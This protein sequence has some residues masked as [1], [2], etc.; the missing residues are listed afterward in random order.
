M[1]ALFKWFT[2]GGFNADGSREPWRSPYATRAPIEVIV[3][4]C[5]GVAW[6]VSFLVGTVSTRP[7]PELHGRGAVILLAII[8]ADRGRGR[9]PA[10][11]PCLAGVAARRRA[12]GK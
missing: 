5:F 6:L 4:R 8:S 7:Y 2:H 11:E 9:H 3:V 10:T 12:G 1:L